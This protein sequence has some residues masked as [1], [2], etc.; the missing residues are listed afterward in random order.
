M[1]L[2]VFDVLRQ[3]QGN[4]NIV[5]CLAGNKVDLADQRQVDPDVRM[6]FFHFSYLVFLRLSCSVCLCPLPHSNFLSVM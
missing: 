1:Y 4:P 3:M 2:L 5:I 6:R